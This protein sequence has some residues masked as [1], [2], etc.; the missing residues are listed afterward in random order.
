MSESLLKALMK[1]FAFVISIDRK[2]AARLTADVLED[3]LLHDFGKEQTN[4]FLTKFR[5]YINLYRLEQNAELESVVDS[6]VVKAI[7]E[8]INTEFEQNQKVW[9][10]LQLIEFIG[11]SKISTPLRIEFVKDV[12]TLFNIREFEFENGKDFILSENNRQ[13][14]WNQQ[15]L[16]IDLNKD[17]ATSEINHITNER[18]NGQIYVLRI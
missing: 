7:V 12:A 9:L 11:D 6:D 13:I 18:L 8:S 16:L 3:Y 2:G 1:L 14:P 17:F 10:I 4:D 5:D 15:V